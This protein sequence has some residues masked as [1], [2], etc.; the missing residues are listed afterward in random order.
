M[1]HYV[2]E[3]I[4]CIFTEKVTIIS[5]QKLNSHII[6]FLWNI[7]FGIDTTFLAVGLSGHM[8]SF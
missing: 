4:K 2:Q 8:Y 3:E 7:N 6:I 5:K 1:Q